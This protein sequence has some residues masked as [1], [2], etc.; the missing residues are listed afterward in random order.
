[1]SSEKQ[2]KTV[3]Q[4]GG[5]LSWKDLVAWKD[6]LIP[7]NWREGKD[8][9]QVLHQLK[10]LQGPEKLGNTTGHWRDGRCQPSLP[11]DRFLIH[12]QP[13]GAFPLL[14]KWAEGC[15]RLYFYPTLLS[16]SEA[17]LC[18][19]ERFSWHLLSA[20]VL[21]HWPA[22]AT[23]KENLG[24]SKEKHKKNAIPKLNSTRLSGQVSGC[25]TLHFLSPQSW[26]GFSQCCSSRATATCSGEHCT[27]CHKLH[28]LSRV[29]W[30]LH[31][32]RLWP[33][34]CPDERAPGAT[35]PNPWVFCKD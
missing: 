18:S 3:I 28:A 4:A 33:F 5:K 35:T 17:A 22:A 31:Q 34:L 9:A 26:Q 13:K 10:D 15:C 25:K 16:V 14:W 6:L 1:M 27:V 19:Q 23:K 2:S 20:S 12:L 30:I 24:L 29:P 11:A 7:W 8:L 21:K 32:L